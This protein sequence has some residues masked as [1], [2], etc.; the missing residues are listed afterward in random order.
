[1]AKYNCPILSSTLFHTDAISL[2]LAVITLAGHPITSLTVNFRDACLDPTELAAV[3]VNNAR[4]RAGWAHL[5]ELRLNHAVAFPEVMEWMFDVIT[6]A[7]NLRILYIN[8][9][10]EDQTAWLTGQLALTD[11]SWSQLEELRLKRVRITVQDLS[12]LLHGCRSTLRVLV[13]TSLDIESSSAGDDLK[14]LFRS[15]AEF[16]A[17]E[18]IHI[19]EV[20]GDAAEYIDRFVHFPVL[21]KDP[22]I[23]WEWET[24]PSSVT[25]QL[26]VNAT[27]KY[28]GPRMRDVLGFLAGNLKLLSADL[29]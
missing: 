17:L 27:V 3:H 25:S 11:I 15:L 23:A 16:P 4:F 28:S 10:S 19:K 12:A 2:I 26:W 9:H 13:L 24:S 22:A 5:R 21:S 18:N 20:F 1:M 6:C 29:L 8:L 7:P 14:A